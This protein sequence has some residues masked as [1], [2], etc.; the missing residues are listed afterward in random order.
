MRQWAA[1]RCVLSVKSTKMSDTKTLLS[2]LLCDIYGKQEQQARRLRRY[3]RYHKS[4]ERHSPKEPRFSRRSIKREPAAK[5]ASSLAGNQRVLETLNVRQLIDV[6][7]MLKVELLMMSYLLERVLVARDRLQRHQEVLCEFVT[8]ILVVE[9]HDAQPKM[10]FSLSPPPPKVSLTPPTSTTSATSTAT[11]SSSSSNNNNSSGHRKALSRNRNNNMQSTAPTNAST[12][13]GADEALSDYN[14]WLHAMKLVARLPGGTPPEFRRKLWLSLADKYLKSK[15]VDWTQ[16]REKCFCEEWREDDE[17]LGIQIVKDLHRTGSNLCT[18]PAGSINQAK[19]KRILLGYARYNPEVGYCQGFNMLGALILQVMDKEEEESMKVMIYLVEGVL[20][21]GYFYG[22]MGGL[23]ADMGVFRE[24]MQTK[25][26]RLAKH[27]QRLQGPM[28]NA[29]EPPLTNV[30]TMQWFLT[31][32]CTCLPMSCVLRVWDLVLIEGSDVLLRT[33]LVLWSLLEERVLNARTADD[34]YGKMGS[35]SNELLNGHLIDS[36]GLIEKVVQLGPIADIKQLRDKHL[37]NIAPLGSKQGLQLYYDE[38]DTQSDDE[39]RLAVATVWGLNWGRRGSVGTGASGAVKPHAEQKDRLALDISLLKKQYDRLRERQRQAHVILTSACSTATATRQTP[40]SQFPVNQLLLGRSAIITNKGKRVGAPLGAI[41]PARK[42]SLPAVLHSKPP[43]AGERQLRRG[44]TL[45]WR[46]TD[47]TRHRRDSLTWKEIKADRAAL[48]RDGGEANAVKSQKLRS[49]LGKSDSSSYSEESDG[50]QEAQAKDGSSTDTSLC[51]DDDPKSIEQSPKRKAKLARKLKEKPQ[52][53]VSRDPS[54]ERR[55]PKSWAPSSH[56]IPFMLMGTDS[57]DEKEPV[58]KEEEDSATECDRFD[59]SRNLDW[60]KA[61]GDLATSKIEPLT[62]ETLP[63]TSIAQLSPLPDVSYLSTASISALPTPR[64][65]YVMSDTESVNP[66]DIADSVQSVEVEKE[67]APKSYDVSDDGVTNQYFERVNSV[68]RPK[69]LEL[70]FSL[71]D[72]D[73]EMS[74]PKEEQRALVEGHS[75]ECVTK[76]MPFELQSKA[77]VEL[78]TDNP[79]VRDDNIPG[80]NKDDYKEVLSMTIETK[81]DTLPMSISSSSRKRRDPRRKTLTRSSTIEIEERFQALERRLSQEKPNRQSASDKAEGAKYIPSTAALEERYNTLEKQLS[82]DKQCVQNVDPEAECFEKPERIPSTADLEIR[83]NALTK[84][85]SSAESNSKAPVELSNQEQPASSNSKEGNDSEKTSK[86]HKLDDSQTETTKPASDSD[87]TDTK[88]TESKQKSETPR[89]KKLPSTAELEDRFNALERRISVQK[90]SPTKAKKEPPDEGMSNNKSS[91]KKVAETTAKVVNK[92]QSKE[93]AEGAK[94]T[95]K[96]TSKADAPKQAEHRNPEASDKKVEQLDGKAETSSNEKVQSEEKELEKSK[97]SLNTEDMKVEVIKRKSPPST[98]ELEKRF[99]ALE[100]Q[101]STSKG[102]SN[103]EVESDRASNINEAAP[104]EETQLKQAENV[105]ETKENETQKSIKAFDEKVKAISASLTMDEKP[106]EVSEATLE[107]RKAFEATC[108]AAN[109]L[110][111][112]EQQRLASETNAAT[113]NTV[114]SELKSDP[115]AKQTEKAQP[116]E[117]IK[118]RASEP[119]SM[120]DLDKRYERLKRR[121]SS[122]NHL[123]TQNETVNEALER[124]EQEVMAELGDSDEDAKPIKKQPPTT[125]DLESRYEALHAQDKKETET[126]SKPTLKSPPRRVDVAIEAHIPEP[127]PPPPP[128]H[129]IIINPGQHQQR[130]LIEEL[131]SKIK[132]QS[133][134][135]ENLKPSEI[136]PQRRRQQEQRQLQQRPTTMGDETS[137]APANTAYYRS[138]NYEPWQ[139]QR[140]VRRFSDLPSRADLENRLQFLE[141]KLYK[142]FYKQ[143]CASDSEV[144]SRMLSYDDKPSTSH[145]AEAQLEQRVLALE[146]QLSENSLKLLEAIREK[147]KQQ[148]KVVHNA[149]DLCSPQRLSSDMEF[150]KEL[151]RYTQNITDVEESDKPINISINIKMLLNKENEQKKPPAESNTDDLRRRLEQ[152]EQQL[153]EARARNGAL[154]P[155]SEV[156]TEDVQLPSTEQAEENETCKKQE[157]DSHNRSVKCDEAEK[158]EDAPVPSMGSTEPETVKETKTLQNEEKAQISNKQSELADATNEEQNADAKAPKEENEN[159]LEKESSPSTEQTKIPD[160]PPKAEPL[161]PDGEKPDAIEQNSTPGEGSTKDTAANIV[162]NPSDIGPV[163][164]NNKTVVLLMDN[165]PKALKVRRLTRANTEELEGLFQA[166]EKQLNDRNLIKSKDGKLVRADSKPSAEQVEQAQAI[167]DLT[168][169]IEDFTSGKPELEETEQK[170][171]KEKPVEEDPNYDWGPNPVKHHLKRKTVYLPSTKE[172]EARFRSL[173]RQIK[174]LEDVEKIDVEQRLCEIERKIKLQYSLSH[175]K[176]LNKY[177]ELCEGKGLDDDDDVPVAEDTSPVRDRS[178]S[179]SRKQTSRSPYTS[180]VSKLGSK[181]PYVSPSR[182]DRSTTKS[183]YTSPTRQCKKTQ[184]TSPARAGSKKSPY[185]SPARRQPHKDDLPISDDLE[186]KYRV[187]DLVRSKSK[188]N[189]SKRKNDPNKKPPIHPLEMLLDPSPDDSEIPTTG[190]LEHRIRLLDEKLKSPVRHKSRSRSPTIEDIKR[191]KMLDDQLPK[192]PVHSL[193]RLVY[194]PSKPEPPTAEELDKRILAL[195]KEQRFD[196]KTQ[197]DYKEFNQKLKDV[198]SPSL[199]YEEFK[200]AKSREQSPRRQAPTTPKSAMRREEINE[201]YRDYRREET[202]PYRPTSPKVIRFRDED[203]DFYED[204]WRPKS[205]QSHGQGPASERM[206]GTTDVLSFMEENSKILQRILKKTLADQPSASTTSSRSYSNSAAA[207]ATASEGVDALGSRLMRETSPITR[208]G[209]HTGVP[210]RTGDNIND[211]LSSIKNSIKSIDSLCEEKS[212]QKEKCQRYIDSLFSD[213]M[214]FASKKSSAE[215]LTH[216]RSESRGRGTQRCS[217]STPTIRISSEHRSLGSVESLRTGSP[218]RAASPPHHRSHRD[219]SRE[220]SPRRRR[221]AEELEERE[222]SR[223]ENLNFPK[224]SS[225][226]DKK[227]NGFKSYYNIKLRNKKLIKTIRKI[228]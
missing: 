24:L 21:T 223:F 30:F 116:T 2:A 174:L 90:S 127:P 27:L 26:P 162:I 52:L 167:S 176:D 210:L 16:Q 195:E 31:M 84:Q 198:V 15:N 43:V 41:P 206:V 217:D 105:K 14:Q 34:F 140:M 55:R 63:I 189:L 100:K 203:E 138:G 194:S 50:E 149:D 177:I 88:G 72:E 186:Y 42:P 179:P 120:E 212:Y 166:L 20:P 213:S 181:S 133:P 141:K 106:N 112:T 59:Y 122:K 33:A 225:N 71:N 199:S 200:L 160:T 114:K 190:E 68:E 197:K 10:R 109:K 173:E 110:L 124:I 28:E 67:S 147:E 115:K 102:D 146:K 224:S 75:A 192:T 214:H 77:T 139:S 128:E 209:T 202:T 32:F 184:Q 155:D 1:D 222:N 101:L 79:P 204:S 60:S 108:S 103:E 142:K 180:P 129:R 172:L 19:L 98:E 117:H 152:L 99:N 191:K 82:A 220:V 163:D 54:L 46:D 150:G 219:V 18:G 13:A 156:N 143:R 125:E 164:A 196:F 22:S 151:V 226:T 85:M 107:K 61:A 39:S 205:R 57:G 23:Q 187:L 227:K 76:S 113:Q 9:T 65:V 97:E 51:D 207:A 169:E 118:R 81:T 154:I 74:S 211:R 73:S 157:K 111:E 66:V 119:P 216:S 53:A 185:T 6:C 40:S 132:A 91:P 80:E 48:F 158:L 58:S 7:A 8:A 193:E 96:E 56:E 36:N 17:E 93:P 62:G 64:P 135:E 78:K 44:E 45:L 188:D 89:L 175:E 5:M 168:K 29:Y 47:A 182:K 3:R 170:A 183:P 87:T 145:Q 126:K 134:G 12:D 171:E 221:E 136:N 161:K 148:E 95:Q 70:S 86:L 130:A 218:L 121:M 35:F 49:R 228:L 69:R 201:E 37:Y 11:G 38:E 131:Q 137:E 215:D 83:F 178:R 159:K 25:L 92:P 104:Q 123:T 4:Q 94:Q 144:A 165:E 153:S 208:T